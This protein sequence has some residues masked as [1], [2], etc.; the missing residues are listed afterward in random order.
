[1]T[2]TIQVSPRK[3]RQLR[4][5]AK[6]IGSESRPR[7]SVYKSN[8]AMYAQLID[9]AKGITLAYASSVKTNKGN[10]TDAARLVGTEIAKLAKAKGVTKIVFDRG[11]FIFTG[12]V[13]ALAD[14]AREGGL[15]F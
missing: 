2:R 7:L 8:T 9:D 13:R 1:M 11:G 5:R 3:R 4:I 14:A 6:V 15:E 10:K 12:R